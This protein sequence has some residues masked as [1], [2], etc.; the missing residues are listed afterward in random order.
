MTII[1]SSGSTGIPKG[2]MLS[3]HNIVSNVN[4][5]GKVFRVTNDENILS[6]LPLFLFMAAILERAGLIDS[7]FDVAYK[8]LGGLKGGLAS[9]WCTGQ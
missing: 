6:A 4:S 9:A 5:L 3:H 1:F 8:C 7:L 2:V